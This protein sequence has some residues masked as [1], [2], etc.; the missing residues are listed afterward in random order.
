MSLE[1]TDIN[2]YRMKTIK[3]GKMLESEIYP[4][5]N[6]SKKRLGDK[7]KANKQIQANLNHKNL[8]KRI[9]I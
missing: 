4:I 9:C 8:R 5:W 3:S 2:R 1:T 7:E 6:T